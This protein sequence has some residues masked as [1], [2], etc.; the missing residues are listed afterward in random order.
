MNPLFELEKSGQSVWLDFVS[1][2]LMESGTLDRLIRQDGVSGLTSNPTIFEKAISKGADYDEDLSSHKEGDAT[3]IFEDLAVADIRRAA[4]AFGAAFKNTAGSDGY[5]SIEVSPRLAR[6]TQ[7]TIVEARRLWSKVGRPNVMIKIPGTKEGLPAVRRC[8]GEGINVNVTLLFSNQ[9]YAEV[10]EAYFSGIEDFVKKGGD[11]RKVASVASFFVSR[12]DTAVD[13]LI[14]K[15]LDGARQP[16]EETAL[17]ALLGKTAVANAK[18]AYRSFK[19]AFG[20][21]RFKGLKAKGAQEQRVLFAST[22][23]KNPAYRDVVYV[24]ELAGPRT[25]NTM[26]LE[27]IEAFRDHG[28]VRSNL[29]EGV[30]GA[31]TSL[32][33]LAACG[34]DLPAVTRSLEEEGVKKF[35]DSYDQLLAVI[36][37]KRKIL[38]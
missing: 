23:T 30:E 6:D 19:Q 10:Q 17:K 14:Q 15:K 3:Q 38:A 2:E 12:V 37:S 22:S 35:A 20:G 25:V 31:E 36:G 9:R 8:I 11:P 7:G 4:D 32:D 18:L 1:R 13:A 28:R 29:E 16:S 26:P 33:K 27:T 34:I 5:V 24:E 21:A